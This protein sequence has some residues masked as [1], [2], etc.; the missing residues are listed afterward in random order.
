MV[1]ETNR[2]VWGSKLTSVNVAMDLHNL[3]KKEGVGLKEAIEFGIK[4]LI[5]DRSGYEYPSNKQT[6][7]IENMALIIQ[8]LHDRI[9]ELG[10]KEEEVKINKP[11]PVEIE[12]EMD[13]VF[14]E[15]KSSGSDGQ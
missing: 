7:K 12:D 15:I 2:G 5:A 14:G 4:Y 8:S 6:L 9:K 10:G 11:D 3:A 13:G 1:E